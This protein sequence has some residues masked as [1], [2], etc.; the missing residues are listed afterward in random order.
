MRCTLPFIKQKVVLELWKAK[1][2]CDS[3]PLG[4]CIVRCGLDTSFARCRCCAFCFPAALH[5]LRCRREQQKERL[6]EPCV[7]RCRAN[8]QTA[9][10]ISPGMGG[11]HFVMYLAD[12]APNATVG[13][14]GP[15]IE[16][17]IFLP[18]AV[19]WALDKSMIAGQRQLSAML[20]LALLLGD[21]WHKGGEWGLTA[22]RK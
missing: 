15:G 9:H 17:W 8:A 18:S 12:L 7:P 2:F 5:A 19:S 20:V 3:V 14:A 1:R 6:T 16:R 22:I 11:A 4:T 21:L 13:R 10:I